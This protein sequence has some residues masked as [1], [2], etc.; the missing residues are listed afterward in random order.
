MNVFL[1]VLGYL[2]PYRVRFALVLA[3]VAA[4][5]ALEVARP[6][7]LKIVVDSV[8]GD[9]PVPAPLAGLDRGALLGAACGGLLALQVTLSILSVLLSRASIAIGQ[10][11][12]GDLRCELVSHLHGQSLGFFGRRPTTDLVYR[13]AFDS[14]AV[15]SMLMNGLFPLISAAALLTGMTLVMLRMNP[16]L[17]GIFLAVGPALFLAIRGLGRRIEGL[18]TELRENESRFLAE[19]QRGVG[20]IHV[21]QAFTAEPREQ[22]RVMTASS[23]ALSSALRLY[24]FETHYSGIV[25]V[26][27]ALGTAAVLYAGGT[28][29]MAG[30]IRAGDLIV[31][32]TYLASLYG[33]INSV[34]QTTGLMRSAAAGARRAFDL[35]DA[36]PEVRDAPDARPLGAVRG[37]VS[38]DNVSFRYAAGE[39]A[40]RGVSF[41]APAGALIALVGPTG[42]G[43]STL[44]SLIP[45][46]YDPSEG[47]VLL[48]GIDL[49]TLARREL[50]ARI[51]IVP[52]SPVLFPATLAENIRYGR[53]E[54]T[55]EE[56]RRAAELAGVA[57]FAAALPKGYETLIG[58]EGQAL[59]QGQ[60]Q[61]VTIARALV[62][63]PRILILDEPT[64]ALDAET[65]SYV[66]S[67]I[68]RAMKDRTT[69][70]IAHRLSTVRRADRVLVLEAGRLVESGRFETLRRAGGLFQRLFDAQ[71]LLPDGPEDATHPPSAD[72]GTPPR[73]AA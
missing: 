16:P 56:V 6:W 62:K 31:F 1:R 13:V 24:V 5:S 15:Q 32:V 66:M 43:K 42:A 26:L 3:G 38:F 28:L 2:R 50:R 54:A 27:V 45:R 33:P 29:G 59:S 63:D 65:E 4:S 55:D 58:Q 61:R 10:R 11:M 23:R 57:P 47:R 40:L 18:S 14:F 68:E 51:G 25:N 7:P 44:A 21:V 34:S 53:P 12:V 36:V 9:A 8:L 49:R 60:M 52:Q 17:A 19:T 70:V 69:F 73:G 30:E 64:S 67:G 41:E 39:P 35:L 37:D 71:F 46:F 20:A 22:E 72:A 48:D